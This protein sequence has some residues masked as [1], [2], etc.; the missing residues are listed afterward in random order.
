MKLPSRDN[1]PILDPIEDFD[2]SGP[3]TMA[4]TNLLHDLFPFMFAIHGSHGGVQFPQI[5]RDCFVCADAGVSE[6]LVDPLGNGFAA[7]QRLQ[8]LRNTATACLQPS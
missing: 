6:I 1:W 5:R 8:I 3:V 4:R 7:A 2:Q